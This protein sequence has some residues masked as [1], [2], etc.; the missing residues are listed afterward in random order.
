MNTRGLMELVALNV[1]Y[2]LGILSP[3]NLHDARAHGAR[4]DG[5]DRAAR[6]THRQLVQSAD[7][8]RGI[9]RLRSVAGGGMGKGSAPPVSM[10]RERFREESS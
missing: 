9:E 1:G 4:D 7:A 10:M 2:D 6:D 8:S 5:H 3:R